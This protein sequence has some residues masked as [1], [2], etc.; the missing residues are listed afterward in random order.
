MS[1]RAKELPEFIEPML[2]KPGKAFDS[3]DY[4]FEIKWDG[5]R[6]L[7]FI[8]ESGYRLVN[9]RRTEITDR[10]P[11]FSFMG[12]L[13][14]G[15][16][17]DGEVVVL[18][19]GKPDFSLL[20]NRE[21]ARN[22]LK[23]RH[24]ANA[25]PATY[26]AF[27][28]LYDGFRSIMGEPLMKRRDRLGEIVKQ[29]NRP[30][31]VLSE[32]IVGNGKAFFQEVCKLGLEGMIAKRFDSRYQPGQRTDAWIKVKKVER[33]SCAIIGYEPDGAADFRSLILAA[34]QNG[35]LHYVGKVGTGIDASMRKKLNALMRSRARAKPF[36]PCKIK[37]K[38][39][40]PGLY[41]M[42]HCMERNASGTLRCP[43]FKDL[44]EDFQDAAR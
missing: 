25:L 32:A 26:V 4:L 8:D 14:A 42:V 21:Q 38:W 12:Q 5:T 41:C 31:I 28:L 13:P 34:E 11:E 15:T 43:V 3:D 39:I 30:Q 36:V 20:M 22:K 44:I 10:Y 19:Q 1:R 7:A 33:V 29:C 18:K 35:E 6:I 37:G 17:L 9:R 24:L 2:S 27:D 16:V 40:E 23:I